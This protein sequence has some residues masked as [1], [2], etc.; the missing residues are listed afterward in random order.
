MNTFV[1]LKKPWKDSNIKRRSPST[2]WKNL[3]WHP[4]LNLSMVQAWNPRECTCA[5]SVGNSFSLFWIYQNITTST[6]S[7]TAQIIYLLLKMLGSGIILP[8]AAITITKN[9]CSFPSAFLC[10]I[11]LSDW[12]NW[13]KLIEK[14]IWIYNL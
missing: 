3:G 8:L 13:G 7:W 9:N 10:P 14:G 12:Q 11:T 6:S 1:C 5:C 4:I 2:R